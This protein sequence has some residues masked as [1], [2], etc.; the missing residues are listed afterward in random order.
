MMTPTVLKSEV[1]I[2]SLRHENQETEQQPSALLKAMLLDTGIH[3][4]KQIDLFAATD[5]MEERMENYD[6][7][8]VT[9]IRENNLEKLRNILDNGGCFNACNR[10]A[11]SLL[12]LACRRSNID[13]VKFLVEEAHVKVEVRD[14]LGRSVLHDICWRPLPDF[15]L[16]EY[17][18]KKVSPSFLLMEDRRGHTCFDYCRKLDWSTWTGFLRV[19]ARS[20]ERRATLYSSI[21]Q[22]TKN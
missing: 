11:E 16:M 1:L 7:E 22:V 13:V 20:I 17:I 18:M 4:F 8:K 19:H 2:D 12:H 9:A 6:M 5:D 21:C 3:K 10:N 14:D 15:E